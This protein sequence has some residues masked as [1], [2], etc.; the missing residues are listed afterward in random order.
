LEIVSGY[1]NYFLG[2][3]LEVFWFV[4]EGLGSQ[5]TN[6][7]V[8][9]FYRILPLA[10]INFNTLFI[11]SFIKSN[12]CKACIEHF[13]M[14]HLL[15][16]ALNWGIFVQTQ[17]EIFAVDRQTAIHLPFPAG[18]YFKKKAKRSKSV[19]NIFRFFAFAKMLNNLGDGFLLFFCRREL[20]R[21]SP[22]N[23]KLRT[24][25]VRQLPIPKV[26]L[27]ISRL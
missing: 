16:M 5:K 4:I 2:M 7:V 27:S 13:L 18:V 25:I 12:G 9:Y 24:Q 21:V 19:C 11:V 17:R 23:C 26:S 6:F 1:G 20:R 14:L 22:I 10:A 3:K 15:S 8:K